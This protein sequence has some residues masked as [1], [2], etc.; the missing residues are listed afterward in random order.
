VLGAWLTCAAAVE[1]QSRTA[2][3]AEGAATHEVKRTYLGQDLYVPQ[4]QQITSAVCIFC[5][6]Q[7]EGD[8]SGRVLVLFGNLSLTGNVGGDVTVLDGNAVLDAQARVGGDIAVLFGNAVYESDDVLSG[9][10]YVL[11][12]HASSFDAGKQRHRRFSLTPRTLGTLLTLG[13]GLLAVLLVVG[14]TG[15]GRP[16][17]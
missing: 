3:T 10:A 13:V 4:G 12:G 9:S 14:R 6:A 16:V 11:G 5:S 17:R 15:R 1:G 8:V 2:L 7:I